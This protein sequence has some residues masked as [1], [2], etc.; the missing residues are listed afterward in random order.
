MPDPKKL[1]VG[2]KV[3][4]VALPDEWNAPGCD[5]DPESVAFMQA[6][7]ARNGPSR[8]CRIDDG[9]YPWIHARMREGDETVVHEWMI[10]E[11]T[12]WR[13]VRKRR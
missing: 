12:G 13:L 2:D 11:T 3:K 8:V 7:I 6:M 4:F 9:G 5:V 10:H 1:N